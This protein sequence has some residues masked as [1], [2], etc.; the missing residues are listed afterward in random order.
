MLHKIQYSVATKDVIVVLYQTSKHI[1][2]IKTMTTFTAKELQA[3][4]FQKAKSTFVE[5]EAKNW[6]NVQLTPTL[7]AL[8]GICKVLSLTFDLPN[9]S[10]GFD[11][12]AFISEHRDT[13]VDQLSYEDFLITHLNN[14]MQ[15]SDGLM[16]SVFP[17][18]MPCDVS[19]LASLALE[20]TKTH[21]GKITLA[22]FTE[23]AEIYTAHL[24]TLKKELLK[25]TETDLWFANLSTDW[26]IEY[27]EDGDVVFDPQ[28]D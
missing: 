28:L 14:L 16:R 18:N 26:D 15:P 10:V 9:S 22:S 6:V 1:L 5:A 19:D 21:S 23:L 24:E 12:Q 4:A 27:N 11:A 2:E 7:N 8:H 17:D 3:A 20:Y 13:I 25:E